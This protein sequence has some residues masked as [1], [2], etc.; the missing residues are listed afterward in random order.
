M[1]VTGNAQ[2]TQNRKFVKF[3]KYNKE[4][5]ATAFVFYCDAKHLD[6]LRG[7]SH[8]SCYLLLGGCSQKWAWS[9]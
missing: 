9:F 2:S 6:T 8:V 7:S 1:K 5:L 3:L 4:K